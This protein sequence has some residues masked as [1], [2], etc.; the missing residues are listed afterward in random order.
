MYV[1]WI[2]SFAYLKLSV[3]W[4]LKISKNNRFAVETKINHI[5]IKPLSCAGFQKPVCWWK[6]T[7]KL[8]GWFP[9]AICGLDEYATDIHGLHR[10]ISPGISQ[11]FAGLATTRTGATIRAHRWGTQQSVRS[12]VPCTSFTWG[13]CGG[14]QGSQGSHKKKGPHRKPKKKSSANSPKIGVFQA[15]S[16][17]WWFQTRI[18]IPGGIGLFIQ[19][20]LNR[21]T[22]LLIFVPGISITFHKAAHHHPRCSRWSVSRTNP[23]KGSTD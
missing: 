11:W 8:P 12:A 15:A 19:N 14:S 2:K 16:T 10:K 18:I 3:C 5:P 13:I 6:R 22:D 4:M 9:W 23:G 1:L 21:Q 7:T 17:G 20:K